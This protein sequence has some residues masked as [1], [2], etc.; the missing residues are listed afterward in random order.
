LYGQIKKCAENSAERSVS[1]RPGAGP[2][3][4]PANA[5]VPRR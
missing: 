1:S 4:Q 5:M 3:Y 2:Q